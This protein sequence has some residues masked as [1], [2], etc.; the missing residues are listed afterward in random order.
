MLVPDNG[1][2]FTSKEF[3][4]FTS[5][6]GIR[7]VKN[8]AYHPSTNGLAKRAVQT[9]KEALKKTSGDLETHLAHFLFQYRTTPH[10]TTGCSPAELLLGCK[11]RT[12]LDQIHTASSNPQ[13]LSA[14]RESAQARVTKVPSRQ[15]EAH[16]KKAKS[17]SFQTRQGKPKWLPGII[18]GNFAPLTYVVEIGK[19][20]L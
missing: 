9:F 2:A 15:K 10:S 1:S 17:R 19:G 7:H 5:R 14:Q 12:P 4:I 3:Q 13:T 16:D 20:R 11:P 18:T 8:A 6:N